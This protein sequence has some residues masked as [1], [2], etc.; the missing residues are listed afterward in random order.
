MNSVFTSYPSW[1]TLVL[2]DMWVNSQ[3]VK[4]VY[5]QLIIQVQ[6]QYKNVI[7]NRQISTGLEYL[8]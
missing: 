2:G 5:H 4:L 8:T 3:V 7:K 1:L 6:C